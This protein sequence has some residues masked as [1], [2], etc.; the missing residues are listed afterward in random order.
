VTV[1]VF[2]GPTLSAAQILAIDSEAR[3]HPPV[4]HGDLL[5]FDL[6]SDDVVVIIDG[7]YHHTGSVRHKEILSLLAAGVR[8]VGCSSM[9]ALRAAE[10][11]SCGMIGNGVVFE[12]YRDGVIDADDEVA[13]AHGDGPE[14]RKFSEPLV[15]IRNALTAACRAGIVS[16]SEVMAITAHARALPYTART[17]R[18]VESGPEKE[19]SAIQPAVR[20]VRAFLAA[21]PEYVDIKATD[22]ID[23]LSRLNDITAQSSGHDMTWSQSL[24]RWEP[25][26]LHEW[27]A[28]FTG[29][30]VG[31]I[32]V[33]FGSIIR[34]RQIYDDDFPR[35]WRAFALRQ[36]LSSHGISVQGMTNGQLED[37]AVLLATEQG[38]HGDSLTVGQ[39]SEWLLDELEQDLPAQ[40]R[41]RRVLVRSHRPSRGIHDLLAEEPDL[42]HD[43]D[44]R[45]AVAESNLVNTAVAG[46]APRQSLN[47]IKKSVLHSHLTGVWRLHG[48][49]RALTAAARDRGFTSLQQ[50]T[51]AV[52]PFFLR[53]YLRVA[54]PA[55]DRIGSGPP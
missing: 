24:Q 12:M 21:H 2:V 36:M 54:G 52:R 44:T 5:R 48:D 20:R 11:S 26:Y 55:A 28:N 19:P 14:Y 27:T 42:V 1:H 13:V 23:T 22:A 9:G 41:L 45:R 7:G 16:P 30:R 8:I 15:N 4:V 35:R 38:L 10:L 25:R 50:A 29:C 33:E 53:H 39:V 43:D 34:Y 6:R 18:G 17:W 49:D 37:R 32:W 47:H 40:E 31:D 46:W 51:S 3:I